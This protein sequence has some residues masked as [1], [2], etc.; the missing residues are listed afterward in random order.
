MGRRITL[1]ALV[2]LAASVATACERP[3]GGD[4]SAQDSTF[5]RALQDSIF[6]RPLDDVQR[7]PVAEGLVRPYGKDT[8]GIPNVSRVIARISFA[9]VRDSMTDSVLQQRA[10]P[11]AA[12]LGANA[13]G[14]VGSGRERDVIAIEV[15]NEKKACRG[16]WIK[17]PDTGEEECMQMMGPGAFDPSSL[18]PVP[19]PE[20]SAARPS[21]PQSVPGGSTPVAAAPPGVPVGAQPVR[22]AEPRRVPSEQGQP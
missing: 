15:G 16:R 19:A 11:Y 9:S 6:V 8:A 4:D 10:L 22:P 3:E 21:G 17:A 14:V 12:R 20:T 5:R 1:A 13:M 2:A 7:S 18:T